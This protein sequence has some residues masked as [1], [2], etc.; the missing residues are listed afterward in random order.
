MKR[1]ESEI[2]GPAERQHSCD[3]LTLRS[4]H[5]DGVLWAPEWTPLRSSNN[6][7]PHCSPLHCIKKDLINYGIKVIEQVT[8]SARAK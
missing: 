2:R 3:L 6:R 8:R 1:N 4:A 5:W 7:H